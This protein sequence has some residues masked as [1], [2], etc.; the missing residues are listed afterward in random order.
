MWK[1]R[2]PQPEDFYCSW[3]LFEPVNYIPVLYG[4]GWFDI[5]KIRD[6][7]LEHGL[8]DKVNMFFNQDRLFNDKFIW[9]GHKEIINSYGINKSA[10]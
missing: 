7:Y 5:D 4:L 10:T 2:L 8:T 9:M 1:N 6:E 3:G